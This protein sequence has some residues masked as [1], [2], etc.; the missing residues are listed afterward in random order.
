MQTKQSLYY[1]DKILSA[2]NYLNQQIDKI[3]DY[4]DKSL[5]FQNPQII[6]GW[7]TLARTIINNQNQDFTYVVNNWK[8]RTE[9]FAET[10]INQRILYVEFEKLFR[11]YFDQQYELKI[12]YSRLLDGECISGDC[13]KALSTENY[14][15]FLKVEDV[16]LHLEQLNSRSRDARNAVYKTLSDVFKLFDAMMFQCAE[17]ITDQ[18]PSDDDIAEVVDCDLREWTLHYG[19]SI[20]R[21]MK[22]DLLR[23]YKTRITDDN[24]YDLWCMMLREDENALK[25]AMRGELATSDDEMQEHWG[26]DT[27]KIMDEN[28]ELMRMIYSS[29]YT[30]ELF[31]LRN[32]DFSHKFIALLTPDNL[33]IFYEIIVR[34]NLIQCEMYPELKSQHENWLKGNNEQQPM[35]DEVTSMNQARRSKLDDIVQLLQKGNWKQPATAE[36]I[37]LFLNT[38]FGKETS[39]LDEEDYVLCEKMWALIEGGRGDRKMIVSSNLAGF[40]SEENLLNGTP[41]EISSELFGN[42]RMINSINDGKKN[43]RSNAFDVVIPFLTKYIDKIIRKV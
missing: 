1:M 40:F 18:N 41:K 30:D 37:T 6:E 4:P 33:E 38:V 34:R 15:K 2:I 14:E 9:P 5:F 11:D 24:R 32:A 7:H 17:I 26:D 35:E 31:E 25:I 43:N 28:G 12:G 19:K 3:D 16:N 22:E 10:L 23:H 21:R 39:L 8:Q 13:I 29:C 20:F 42:E 36:N 27:K